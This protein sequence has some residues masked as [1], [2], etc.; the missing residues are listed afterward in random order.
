MVLLRLSKRLFLSFL[1]A[2]LAISLYP[3]SMYAQEGSTSGAEEDVVAQAGGA[4]AC[5]GAGL[6]AGASFSFLGVAISVP[7]NSDA[8]NAA[9]FGELAKECVLD[10]IVTL[11]K[12][13]LIRKV[14]NSIVTWIN[15]GFEG[16][17]AFVTNIDQFLLDTADEAFGA[18]I[19][20]NE[21]FA[22][23]C[24]PFQYDIRFAVALNY[25][26]SQYRPQC[27]LS[28]IV[29]NVETAID[30][31]SVEW[32]WDVYETIATDPQGNIFSA[33]LDVQEDSD[34]FISTEIQKNRDDVARGNGFLSFE[35]CEDKATGRNFNSIG[36]AGA[37]SGVDRGQDAEGQDL[38]DGVK[39]AGVECEIVTPGSVIQGTLQNTIDQELNR[40]GFADEINEIIG[41]LIGQL[42]QQA[43]GIGG[44]GVRGLSERQGSSTSFLQTYQ[45]DASSATRE[46]GEQL[47]RDIEQSSAAQVSTYVAT[48]NE[49]LS[50][51][52]AA[53]PQV[54]ETLACYESKFNTW[55]TLDGEVIPAGQV[56]SVPENQRQRAAFIS[57]NFG[58][59]GIFNRGGLSFDVL[60][61]AEAEAKVLEYRSLLAR[62]RGDIQQAQD[63]IE[64]ARIVAANSAAIQEQL[65]QT[66]DP[67]RLQELYGA[68]GSNTSNVVNVELAVASQQSIN[69]YLDTGLNGTT[70]FTVDGS[71]REGG[72]IA[73]LTSCRA[74]TEPI[75]SPTFGNISEN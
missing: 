7:V 22:F 14:T 43:L 65:E 73:D 63:G 48:Q 42:S 13:T 54:A 72:A 25:S 71:V 39:G 21:N 35:K 30:D 70:R 9:S 10:A 16:S 67:D 32:D 5:V 33:Y 26:T 1:I 49:N 4:A 34:N 62:I 41:A 40:L 29:D 55:L 46:F 11:L 38:P 31:L 68:F 12:E 19:Y 24:A 45:G 6:A 51:L 69:T 58:S 66:G 8:E 75:E 17:P 57:Q 56:S 59:G 36:V 50:V 37:T 53:E 28:Q 15:S 74:F 20:N 3:V 23:L 64:Q 47:S 61:S 52:F 44:G 60:T 27:T 18:Y 2:T